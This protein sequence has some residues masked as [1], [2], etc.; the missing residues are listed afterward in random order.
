MLLQNAGVRPEVSS[1][2]A[3]TFRGSS[4]LAKLLPNAGFDG[5]IRPEIAGS[6]S[7]GMPAGTDARREPEASQSN[8]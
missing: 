6:C 8:K 2:L 1:A 3:E 4:A 5:S 7:Y